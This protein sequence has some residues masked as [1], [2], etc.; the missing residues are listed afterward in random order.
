[1][2]KYVTVPWDEEEMV[3]VYPDEIAWTV[4]VGNAPCKCCVG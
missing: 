2:W 3:V 4:H 1:M